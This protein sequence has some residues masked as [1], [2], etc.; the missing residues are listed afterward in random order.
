MRLRREIALEGPLRSA[1]GQSA[2]DVADL[3]PHASSSGGERAHRE[4]P[5]LRDVV[6]HRVAGVHHEVEE[7]LLELHAVAADGRE[8]R[9]KRRYPRSRRGS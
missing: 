2:P 3:D 6:G 4:T 7:H 1:R 8:V 9:R 5:I